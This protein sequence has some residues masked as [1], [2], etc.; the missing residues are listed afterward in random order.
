MKN[1]KI[2]FI[3][4]AVFILAALILLGKNSVNAVSCNKHEYMAAESYNTGKSYV[5]DVASANVCPAGG[6]DNY[7][8][9]DLGISFSKPAN[10]NVFIADGTVYVKPSLEGPTGVFLTPILR[11]NPKMQAL[12]FIRF[13]YDLAKKAYPDLSLSDKRSNSKDTMAE[14]SATFTN[15]NTLVKG[16]YM[17]SIDGGRGIF[18]G[19]EDVKNNFDGKYAALRQ[20]LKTLK[21]EPQP[22]YNGTSGEQVYG[23]NAMAANNMGPTIDTGHFVTKG[24][25]DGTMYVAC[26]PDW[27]AGGGNYFYI[28]HS[29]DG[30][31]G[32]FTSNDHQP[33]TFD[34]QSYLMSQLMPFMKCSNTTITKTEP[35]YDYM[36]MLQSQGVPSNA[37]NFYGE[38]INGAG[39]RL[40][41]GIMV[42][43]TQANGVPGG[44][45]TTYGVFAVPQLF[46]RNFNTLTAMAFSITADNA[47]IMGNLRAN[48][49]RL[50]AASKTISQTGDIT[51]SM[52]RSAAAGTDRIIDKYNYYQSGEDA[53]YSPLED[54]IYVV[55][56]NLADYASNPNYPQEMLTKV[57]DNKWNTLPHDRTYAP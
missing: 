2:V 46:D 13:V 38:T 15:K 17:V 27:Q 55:D 7:V 34:P 8:N 23:G 30:G 51:I 44:Y 31:M 57:P 10:W 3:I 41:Y 19:Y 6:Y 11:A 36:K 26:P 29:P 16:F 47:V 45:V 5:K 25:V 52:V 37:A 53:R 22:F 24:S 33:K 43:V 54:K 39:L 48:L 56:S 28:A 21:V 1:K 14:V 12:S 50:D 20:I 4:I 40:K 35:N 42:S 9:Q 49:A 32:V 18:C